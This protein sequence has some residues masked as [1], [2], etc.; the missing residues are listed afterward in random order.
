MSSLRLSSHRIT[1]N[2]ALN[3][4]IDIIETV[5]ATTVVLGSIHR[6]LMQQSTLFDN[7]EDHGLQSPSTL[8]QPPTTSNHFARDKE[9]PKK[10]KNSI[11]KLPTKE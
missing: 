11:L 4:W 9:T 7:G 2:L 10:K 3:Q 8:F 5:L 1:S 6:H